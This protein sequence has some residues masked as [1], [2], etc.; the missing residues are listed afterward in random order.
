MLEKENIFRSKKTG[1]NLG[2]QS[3]LGT[4]CM[5]NLELNQHQVLYFL[6]NGEK[7][8]LSLIK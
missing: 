2:L 1:Q 5:I 3:E 6:R 8:A 7:I 4:T